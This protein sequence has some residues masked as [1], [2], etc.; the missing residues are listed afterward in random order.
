MSMQSQIIHVTVSAWVFALIRKVRFNWKYLEYHTSINTSTFSSAVNIHLDVL[1]KFLAC[2]GGEPRRS[3]SNSR[4]EEPWLSQNKVALV[5][6]YFRHKDISE[7]LAPSALI[8]SELYTL[9]ILTRGT[10]NLLSRMLSWS[11]SVK[12]FKIY[13]KITT[14]KPI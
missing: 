14:S 3:F 12:W 8:F 9:M 5:L 7:K 11:S 13:C 1:G 6:E 2:H 4:F 10:L